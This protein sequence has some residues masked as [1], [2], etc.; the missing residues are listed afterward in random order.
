MAQGFLKF[1]YLNEENKYAIRILH[2]IDK[3]SSKKKCFDIAKHTLNLLDVNSH[4]IVRVLE[5]A[6]ELLVLDK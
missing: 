5:I 3:V 1:D 6:Y 2:M 4:K